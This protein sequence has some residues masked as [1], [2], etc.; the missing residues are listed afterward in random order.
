MALKNL[1]D[2]FPSTYSNYAAWTERLNTATQTSQTM[3]GFRHFIRKI[4]KEEQ[5]KL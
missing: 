5:E 2:D 1:F 3:N 4:L